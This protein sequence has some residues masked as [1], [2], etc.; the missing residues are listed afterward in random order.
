MAESNNYPKE[1]WALVDI[2][3]IAYKLTPHHR[4][5]FEII[6]TKGISQECVAIEQIQK[7]MI[8]FERHLPSNVS[9]W[10]SIKFLV[11]ID[12]F[13][14]Q[15]ISTGY[16]NFNL[17]LITDIGKMVFMA[18]F[19]RNVGKFEH[20]LIAEDHDNVV[21]G[22]MIQ[23]V[24]DILE[25]KGIYHFVRTDRE[26]NTINLWGGVACIPDVIAVRG[27]EQDLF[28]VEC[29]NHHQP[30]FDDKM[31]KLARATKCINIIVPNRKVLAK[32]KKQVDSWI[33]TD[34]RIDLLRK[35]IHV[36]LATINDLAND[37]WA[38]IYDMT[39]NE[40]VC[41]FE[42]KKKGGESR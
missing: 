40:P 22:Y 39:A 5:V 4:K 14:V 42:N 34:G 35:G 21:H 3:R 17:L 32:L 16:R 23:D 10:R 24:K 2:N 38:Y 9:T 26:S 6:V 1:K 11:D 37:K 29:A 41:C 25:R 36:R 28:E 30:D 13:N 18:I 33:A 27:V 7:E 8:T 12:L 19:D 15:K 31:R 20:E